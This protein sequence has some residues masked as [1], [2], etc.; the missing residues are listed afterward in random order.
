MLYTVEQF[1]YGVQRGFRSYGKGVVLTGAV[2]QRRWPEVRP[3]P[4]PPPS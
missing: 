2:R 4:G 3:H 1:P